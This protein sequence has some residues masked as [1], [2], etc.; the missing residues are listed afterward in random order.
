MALSSIFRFS[1]G[2]DAGTPQRTGLEVLAEDLFDPTSRDAIIA[3]SSWIPALYPIHFLCQFTA[4]QGKPVVVFPGEWVSAPRGGEL[5]CPGGYE[6]R[7]EKAARMRVRQVGP[8]PDFVLA[9]GQIE[10]TSRAADYFFTTHGIS[11][12][13]RGLAKRQRVAL[14]GG[15][16]E[17]TFACLGGIVNVS[18][19]RDGLADTG[20]LFVADACRAQIFSGQGEIPRVLFPHDHVTFEN[21]GVP[22]ESWP[23]LASST[24]TNSASPGSE[25]AVVALEAGTGGMVHWKNPSS[26]QG[27]TCTLYTQKTEFAPLVEALRSNVTG[28]SGEAAVPAANL[29]QRVSVVCKNGNAL[30]VSGVVGLEK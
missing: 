24:L 28:A 1:P 14:S 7:L 2:I 8:T 9:G 11:G 6:V 22:R 18:V 19:R 17:N 27:G 21:L 4:L 3:L 30:A 26:L 20:A 15:P 16:T 25:F 5:K 13:L 29:P 10:I 12:G 23:K